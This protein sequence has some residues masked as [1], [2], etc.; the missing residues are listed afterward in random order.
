MK[1]ST[2]IFILL[3]FLA[4][5]GFGQTADSI[6]NGSWLKLKAALQWKSGIVADLLKQNFTKSPKIDKTQ[7][8]VA[9]NMALELYKRVDTLQTRDKFSISGVYALNTSLATLVGDIFNAPKKTRRFW[10]RNDEA[11][12]LMSQLEA[13]ENR[14]AVARGQYNELCNQYKMTD[15]FFGPFEPE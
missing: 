3:I 6:L 4:Q 13:C 15:L 5:L 14:I 2:P 1:P 7:I 12:Q 9:Q 10:R 11:L 8:G